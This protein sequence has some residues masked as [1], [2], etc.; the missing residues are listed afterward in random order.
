MR[1]SIIIV[2]DFHE[3]PQSVRDY[4]ISATYT[5][6]EEN[7]FPG[8]NSTTGFQEDLLKLKIETILQRPIKPSNPF[9]YFRYSWKT[10]DEENSKLQK[11]HV[12][13]GWEWGGVCYLSTPEQLKDNPDS[14]TLFARHKTLKTDATPRTAEEAELFGYSHY[15]ELRQSIIYGDGLDFEIEITR[16]PLPFLVRAGLPLTLILIV[17]LVTR[18]TLQRSE[19]VQMSVLSGL[20]LSIFAYSIY[21]NDRI[22][23]TDYLTFGD[24]MWIGALISIFSIIIGRLAVMNSDKNSV[25]A[26][27]EFVSTA[28]AIGIYF[29]ILLMAIFL[30]FK[31]S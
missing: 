5:K 4:A 3:D 12:D 10:A 25:R 27:I 16:T 28:L 13:N 20:L 7:T 23:E 18:K 29:A 11:V 30:N 6:K 2:D 26:R 8:E 21:L 31:L 15:D 14:G 1:R 22:P 24:Y 17:A 9:G 19:D